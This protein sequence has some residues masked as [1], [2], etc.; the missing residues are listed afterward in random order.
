MTAPLPVSPDQWAVGAW[1]LG[2]HVDLA[3]GDTTFAVAAPQATRLTVEFFPR[4]QGADAEASFPLAQG[5]DGVWRGRFSG[6]RHGT[7]YGFRAWGT[8]WSFDPDWTPGSLAGFVSDR[9]ADFNHLNPNKVLFDPYAREVTHNPLSLNGN[10]KMLGSG[11]A[12]FEG[13]AGREIDSAQVAPKAVVIEDANATGANPSFAEEDNAIYEAHVKNLTLHPNA[14]TLR[15]LLAG[16][17]GFDHLPDI[18][19]NLRGTYAGA[20]LMAPYLSALGLTVI[21]LLPV[22][23]TDSDQVGAHAGTTNHWGYQTLGFFAPNRDYSSDKSLGGPTREFKEMVAAF[24]A[25][26]VKVYL[27]VV[28]NHSAEGGNWDGSADAAGFTTLGGF[29]TSDYYVLNASGGLIDGATGTSNQM[30]YS[31]P[32]SCSLVMDSLE[33]WHGVMGVDGFRFDLA[34]VLGRRPADAAPED[35]EAQR[36]FFPDH[37]LLVGIVELAQRQGF[38]VVAEAW[39]LWGYEVG[40]FPSGWGEWNGRFRDAMRGYLKGD[41]NTDEF[42]ALFNGDYVHFHDNGGP[43][44]SVNFVT[45]HDGFTMLD[46]VSY[47]AKVN[48]QPFPFGPSDG[49]SDNNTSWDSGGDHALRRTR[50]RNF[51]LITFLARGVPMIVSGDEYGRTQNGNNNPWSLNTV[52]MWNNW[53]QAGSNDPTGL[54]VDP[55]HPDL[56]GYHDNIGVMPD[57]TNA[58]LTF[59]RYVARLRAHQPSLRQRS[60]GDVELGGKDV[61]YVYFGTALD[62]PPRPGDRQIAVAIDS[63]ETEGDDFWV[64]LNMYDQPATFDLAEALEEDHQHEWRRIIDT[65]SWAEADGNAWEMDQAQAVTGSYTVEPWSIAV[66]QAHHPS[67]TPT[68]P[69][70]LWGRGD[71]LQV[72]RSGRPYRRGMFG[73]FLDRVRRDSVSRIERLAEAMDRHPAGQSPAHSAGDPHPADAAGKQPASEDASQPGPEGAAPPR[74]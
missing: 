41:G 47:N 18:P 2:A 23:E 65:S 17:P 56:P 27:D 67:V 7:L 19:Q 44:K 34:P 4:A 66:L 54:P 33:Y 45:A 50:W 63:G 57:A 30:N 38:E 26:G 10:Q 68:E 9:D 20:G 60:W 35:W 14:L 24:H 51:W 61:S 64:L 8:N 74:A 15:E 1:P 3:S 32:L 25:A 13:R 28:Y 43:H 40:N 31:S 72:D 46:L 37:P 16:T 29:A 71:G 49:G 5:P 48:D 59:A 11:P 73:S 58:L 36:R 21:E 6:A 39:D 70:Q 42:M 69:Q 12:E 52:G 55:Q 62:D 22:H 53:A